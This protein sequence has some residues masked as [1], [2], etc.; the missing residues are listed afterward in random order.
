MPDIT[1]A[2]D[3]SAATTLLHD[4]EAALGT[5]S[6]SGGGPLGPFSAS[7]NA[8]ASFSDG[9]IDLLPPNI[10]QITNC[11]FNY[12]VGFSISVDLNSILP[13]FCLPQVC[14]PIPFDGQICTPQICISW[15]TITI[16]VSYSD[17]IQ[18]SADFSLVAHLAGSTWLVDVVI[19]GIPSLDLSPAAVAILAAIE[20]AVTPILLA[21]PFI[22]PFLALAVDAILT[23]IGIAGLLGAMLAFGSAQITLA[24]L[25]LAPLLAGSGRLG[26][27]TPAW[28]L[29]V[30]SVGAAICVGMTIAGLA[31]GQT[32]ALLW[33]VPA[34]FAA[35]TLLFVVAVLVSRRGAAAA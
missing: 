27:V 35:T 6:T 31:F 22:G 10:I 33:A 13:S 1:L 24:P 4:A 26:T 12:S 2:V 21:I 15:P 28:A 18:F 34:C 30:L 23:A 3:Q 32:V 8:S 11:N 20:L 7:W 16:P 14:I 19:D 9:V 29:A 5:Q 17:T 25:V